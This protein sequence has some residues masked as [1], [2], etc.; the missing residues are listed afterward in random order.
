M[1]S[2]IH[3]ATSIDILGKYRMEMV[4]RWSELSVQT[5]LLLCVSFPVQTP[6]CLQE[7]C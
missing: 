4:M 3:S 1:K 2:H 5:E 6:S 7:G